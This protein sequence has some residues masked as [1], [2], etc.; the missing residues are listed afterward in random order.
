MQNSKKWSIIGLLSVIALSLTYML[1]TGQ[2]SFS[3]LSSDVL[4]PN[5]ICTESSLAGETNKYNANIKQYKTVSAEV[6]VLTASIK[7]L[8]TEISALTNNKVNLEAEN[9]SY[10]AEVK[11]LQSFIATNCNPPRPNQVAQCNQKKNKVTTLKAKITANQTKIADLKAKITNKTNQVAIKQAQKDAKLAKLLQLSPKIAAYETCRLELTGKPTVASNISGELKITSGEVSVSGEV[12]CKTKIVSGEIVFISG[13][14]KAPNMSGE[15]MTAS[16]EV[17]VKTILQVNVDSMVFLVKTAPENNLEIKEWF[18]DMG[19]GKNISR[20]SCTSAQ[21]TSSSPVERKVTCVTPKPYVSANVIAPGAKTTFKLVGKLGLI[22]APLTVKTQFREL[23]YNGGRTD[24]NDMTK[25]AVLTYTA[26][27]IKLFS[28]EIDTAKKTADVNYCKNFDTCAHMYESGN[29]IDVINKNNVFCPKTGPIKDIPLADLPLLKEGMK[30]RL[31]HGNESIW[32]NDVVVT[33]KKLVQ[34]KVKC[35]FNGSK[36][37]QRCYVAGDD[38]FS[39]KGT[40]A[41]VV[42]VK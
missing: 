5:F 29:V 36:I 38:T 4:S 18:L 34:E 39:C 20:T 33:S 13:E 19:E 28:V 1:S 26:G 14:V 21:S 11:T 35:V 23:K 12:N 3:G 31:K 6:Q 8:N 27:P 2:M 22:D 10:S 32:S 25:E 9:V 42:D 16:G 15:V 24:I 7:T 30:V 37:E 40:D 41:C 17:K